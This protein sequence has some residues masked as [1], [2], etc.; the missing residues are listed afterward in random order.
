MGGDGSILE[1]KSLMVGSCGHLRNCA[2]KKC[3]KQIP[4]NNLHTD[5]PDCATFAYSY[6][7]CLAVRTTPWSVVFSPAGMMFLQF[8]FPPLRVDSAIAQFNK[9]LA[10]EFQ[11]DLEA[12]RAAEIKRGRK[13]GLRSPLPVL[14]HPTHSGDARGV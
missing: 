11:F 14:F 12:W 4:H 8:C 7:L 5:M 3:T 6:R 13:V 9:K 10:S 1:H 2:E